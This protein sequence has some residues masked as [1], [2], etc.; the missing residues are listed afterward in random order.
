MPKRAFFPAALIVF[1]LIQIATMMGLLPTVFDG[2]W[3]IIM[4]VA[5][6]GGLLISD[7][8]EW[9]RPMPSQKVASRTSAPSKSR[10]R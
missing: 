5:G 2:F 8:E 4:I 9:V 6:L 7:C 10:R 1:G 3:P